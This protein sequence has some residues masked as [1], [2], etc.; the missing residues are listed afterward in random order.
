[1]LIL[2]FSLSTSHLMSVVCLCISLAHE[3]M[4]YHSKRGLTSRPALAIF[5]T[6]LAAF[7]LVSLSWCSFFWFIIS[8]IRA[9]LM[10]GSDGALA[11]A[12]KN[13]PPLR[14]MIA[15]TYASLLLVRA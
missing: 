12:A 1:M 13:A 7:L 3:L 6:I 9:A 11:S 15:Q 10:D 8:Q 14:L 2:L 5:I 4:K